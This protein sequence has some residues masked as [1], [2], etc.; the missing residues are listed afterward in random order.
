MSA[1]GSADL[2]SSAR[3]SLESQ[4]DEQGGGSVLPPL[5]EKLRVDEELQ[6]SQ[7]DFIQLIEGSFRHN[8]ITPLSQFTA[9][10]P[11]PTPHVLAQFSLKVYKDYKERETDEQYEKLLALLDGWKILTTA[12]N[13]NKT[14][15]YF[16][17][18]LWL[19]EH[20]QVVIAHRG[21]AN[22]GAAWTDLKG[23]V[24]NDYVRQMESASTFAHKVVE[25]LR[26][27]N[28]M[29]GVSFQLFFT[30]HSLGDW[31]AQGTTFTTEYLEKKGDFSLEI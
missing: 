21:T 20:Q 27:V 4:S 7:G 26:E 18:A 28:R 17:V 6:L 2:E 12:S 29:E 30:G 10:P 5:S 14:N 24:L 25:V 19:P 13:G 16:G 23:V 9:T 15:G 1:L 8:S 22:F 11:F 31:L 3:H